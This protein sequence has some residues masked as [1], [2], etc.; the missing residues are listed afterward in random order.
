VAHRPV[1]ELD[2]TFK[3]SRNIDKFERYDH[4]LAGWSLHKDRYTKCLPDPPLVV[5]ICRDRSNAKEFCRAADPVVTAAHAHGGE[6]TAEWPHPAR[7]RMFF[8]A[9]RDAHEGRLVGYALPPE[10]PEVRVQRAD[11]DLNARACT[12]GSA[13]CGR[14]RRPMPGRA[15]R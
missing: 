8:V 2:R 9:E 6:Y 4:M 7:E 3:P 1:V 10:P 11:G 5:F 14:G 15:R 12:R 13:G